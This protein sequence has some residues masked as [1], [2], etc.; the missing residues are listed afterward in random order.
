MIVIIVVPLSS[1][2]GGSSSKFAG[3][4]SAC[5]L[6]IDGNKVSVYDINEG[7]EDCIQVFFQSGLEKS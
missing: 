2:N 1:K 4:A 6:S 7:I 3:S 5:F